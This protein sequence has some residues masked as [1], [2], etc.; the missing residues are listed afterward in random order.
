M[1]ALLM[2]LVM[3]LFIRIWFFLIFGF[4]TLLIQKHILSQV[5]KSLF[6][7]IKNVQ[8]LYSYIYQIACPTAIIENLLNLNTHG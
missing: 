4:F 7:L 5:D 1:N 8:I 2:I 6:S 3:M